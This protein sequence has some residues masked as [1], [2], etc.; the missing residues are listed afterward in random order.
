D[1]IPLNRPAFFVLLAAVLLAAVDR[2]VFF[3]AFSV[4]LPY[5]VFYVAY[6]FGGRIRAFNRLGDYSYGIYIYAFPV[7]QTIAHL[8]PGVSVASLMGLSAIA[9]VILAMLSWHL[10][11]QRAL[12]LQDVAA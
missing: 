12:K 1:R 2:R 11:E 4:A 6:G 7:E 9:T 8:V 3:F 10:L 5:F